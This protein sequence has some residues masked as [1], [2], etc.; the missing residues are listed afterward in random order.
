MLSDICELESLS[1][2]EYTEEINMAKTQL[3]WYVVEKYR[4]AVI[5][6]RSQKYLLGEAPVRRCFYGE[7]RWAISKEILEND[8]KGSARTETQIITE[9]FQDPYNYLFGKSIEAKE[10]KDTLKL[11]GM[12]AIFKR[13]RER[14]Y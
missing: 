10:R 7:M 8:H 6:L 11:I 5:R 12:R 2:S 1:P 4:G 13:Q 14:E 9:A 3:K